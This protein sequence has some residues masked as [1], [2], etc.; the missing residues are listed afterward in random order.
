MKTVL[1][2]VTHFKIQEMGKNLIPSSRIYTY[3]IYTF[4]I[5]DG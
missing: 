1:D 3:Q 5:D 2:L 4:F